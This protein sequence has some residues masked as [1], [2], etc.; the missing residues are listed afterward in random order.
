MDDDD[1]AL[2]SREILKSNLILPFEQFQVIFPDMLRL[3]S[4]NKAVKQTDIL[5]SPIEKE[6]GCF[7]S[8]SN[9]KKRHQATDLVT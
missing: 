8:A 2:I 4:R 3:G 6:W 5:I 7:S 1:D 9:T